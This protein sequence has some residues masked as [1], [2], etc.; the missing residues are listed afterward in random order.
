M[1]ERRLGS[2]RLHSLIGAGGMGEVYSA[3]DESLQRGV[4]IKVLPETSS[5]DAG[6]R[7]RLLREARAA[8]AL[9]HPNICTIYEVGEQDGHAFIAM[10]LVDGEP[11][12]R[13]IPR[14]GLPIDQVLAYGQQIADALAH[15]HERGILHRDLKTQN[16]VITKSGRAKILDFGLAKRMALEHETTTDGWSLLTAT[17]TVVGTPAYMS[18]EQLRGAGSDARSDI[19]ALGVVLYE[20][21]S[22][23]R[24]FDGGTPYEL[25]S[26]ILSHPPRA[27]PEGASLELRPIVTKC[28][29]KDAADRFQRAD[30][31]RA[32]LESVK[33]G[34]APLLVARSRLASRARKAAF[35]TTA[36]V[37]LLSSI[38]GLTVGIDVI[39]GLFADS[40]PRFDSIAVLPLDDNSGLPDQTYLTHGIQ[41]ALITELAQLGGFTK[42]IAASSTRRF[43]D[44]EL[45]HAEIAQALGVQALV[46]GSIMRPGNRVRFDVQLI[47]AAT[48]RHVWTDTYERP[49]DEIITLQNNVIGDVARAIELRVSPEDR[50]RLAARATISPETYELYLRGMAEIDRV[51]DGGEPGGGLDYLQQA[52][53]RDPGD[54][55][56]Y[57]GLAKGW[58]A[59]GHSPN[60]PRDAWIQARAAADRAMKLAPDLAD[61]HAAMA[62]VKMYSDWDWSGAEQSFRRA[63]ELNPN[64]A[65]NHYH[66]AW[67]LF[68]M[69]RLDEA[70]VEHERARDL[71]P[72]TPLQQ[73]WLGSLYI[74]AER[75][76]EARAA[77]E[78]ALEINPN[79]AVAFQVLSDL[80]ATLGRHDEAIAAAQ[81]AMEIAPRWTFVLAIAYARAGRPDDA[82]AAM[83]PM[84]SRQPNGYNMWA[85]S[86]AYLYL[87]D[88][89]GFF[90][91]IA[92]EPHHG[93]A[94]WVVAEPPI[95][96]F[97]SDPR[98]AE[99]LR[100]FKLPAR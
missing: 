12:N 51:S 98:Y 59:L 29:E 39:R 19:W 75:Y 2:Y 57:A 1:D 91:S 78:K 37:V 15:A 17:G 68:L 3:Y 66:Y 11:L 72:M 92:Y 7:A 71:D 47:E 56:A 97:K 64:L 58:V 83:A 4:A 18:P 53:D 52:I 14:D 94:P 89:D 20:M 84:L 6:A 70:I 44:T 93:W 90:T 88:V 86:M 95:E 63:N 23:R 49:L 82:R 43:R 61:A 79:A 48:E 31:V 41:Q 25:S 46:T 27:L 62:T 40:G 45:S 76:E 81:R 10:E 35:A 24:P 42:V 73:A 13:V 38:V 87:G 21:A 50:D 67:F 80:N 85:R 22:G 54:A 26:A 28:L 32:A 96:K 16:V 55:H 77:A 60:G 9:N 33:S 30:D 5:T 74:V 65:M 36:A 8:A 100:R 99:L 69:G 34:G